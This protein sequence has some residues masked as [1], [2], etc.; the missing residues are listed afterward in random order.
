MVGEQESQLLSEMQNLGR[1]RLG[2]LQRT[3]ISSQ[4]HVAIGSF[5]PLSEL[6]PKIEQ[7][8]SNCFKVAIYLNHDIGKEIN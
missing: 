8:K 6:N 3:R 2:V 7:I 1:P 5:G 4:L